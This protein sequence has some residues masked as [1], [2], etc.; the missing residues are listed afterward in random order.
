MAEPRRTLVNEDALAWMAA[1]AAPADASVVTSLPDVSELPHLDLEG[2]RRWFIAAARQV[3]AWTPREGASIFFQSDI[4]VGGAI[5]DKSYLV[6]RAAEQEG[7]HLLWH[8]IVCRRPPGTISFGRPSWS[9]M[10]CVAHVPRPPARA[11]GPDVLPDAGFMPWSRAMG[12]TACR[13]A[14]TYLRDEVRARTIVDPFCGRGT[15]LAVANAMGLD[16]LGVELSAQRCRAAR[17]LVVP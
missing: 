3:I 10:L 9:H 15:V 4:R 14:C 13:V 11:P 8:K 1:N 12:V 2:W 5:V 16:A 7:A 17:A 6:M